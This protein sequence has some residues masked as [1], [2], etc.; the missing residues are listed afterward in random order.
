MISYIGGMMII[1][2]AVSVL[3]MYGMNNKSVSRKYY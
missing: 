1:T 3:A 2:G